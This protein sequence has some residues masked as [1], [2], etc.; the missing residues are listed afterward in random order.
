MF[1]DDK[2]AYGTY[3]PNGIKT[4]IQNKWNLYYDVARFLVLDGGKQIDYAN[5]WLP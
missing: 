2:T 3:I 4:N 5:T 1:V